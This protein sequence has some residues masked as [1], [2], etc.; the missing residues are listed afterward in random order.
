MEKRPISTLVIRRLPRYYRYLE[1]LMQKG[2][3][4]ISSTELGRRMGTT[5]SQIRQDLNCF[6]GFGQQGY[7]Y[8]VVLLHDKIGSILGL[9]VAKNAVMIGA[10]N[11]GHALGANMDMKPLGFNLVRIFDINPKIV[12]QTI[13]NVEVFHIDTLDEFAK[14]VNIDVAILTLPKAATSPMIEKLDGLGVK[15]IWNFSN[16][17]IE[18]PGMIVENVHLSDSLM[19]LSYRVADSKKPEE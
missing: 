3:T 6:G 13:G 14:S 8:N 4:K 18:V 17:D 16:E 2:V 1:E 12:G 15:A 10:G 11:L 19:T 9:D 7:G 5:A